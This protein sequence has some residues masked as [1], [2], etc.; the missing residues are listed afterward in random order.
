LAAL[1]LGPDQLG[2]EVVVPEVA[3]GV[4]PVVDVAGVLAL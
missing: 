2:V 4:E 3:L 1:G